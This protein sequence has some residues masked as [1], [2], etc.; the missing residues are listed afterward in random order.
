VYEKLAEVVSEADAPIYRHR[1]E[2]F[3][4]TIRYCAYNAGDEIA[5]EDLLTLRTHGDLM[6]DFSVRMLLIVELR[7]DGT[8]RREA[9]VS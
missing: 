3:N 4:P 6:A 1:V 5:E 7:Q 8:Y 9:H 2:E